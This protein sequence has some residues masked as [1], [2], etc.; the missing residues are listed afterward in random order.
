ME[1]VAPNSKFVE[2]PAEIIQQRKIKGPL[3]HTDAFGKTEMMS[4]VGF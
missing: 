2:H 1:K 4:P 3:L